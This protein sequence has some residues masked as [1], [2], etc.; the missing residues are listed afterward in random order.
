MALTSLANNPEKLK[1]FALVL[2]ET[3]FFKVLGE[4]VQ[5][6]SQAFSD[7][8]FLS[9]TLFATGSLFAGG[10]LRLFLSP[11]ARRELGALG[12]IY[13]K[14]AKTIVDQY[15][16]WLKDIAKTVRT[17]FTKSKEKFEELKESLKELK[18]ELQERTFE[19]SPVVYFVATLTT[20]PP[21][22]VESFKSV[23]DRTFERI[24]RDQSKKSLTL[25][26]LKFFTLDLAKF[27]WRFVRSPRQT[28]I[29]L[30]SKLPLIGSFIERKF[31]KQEETWKTLIKTI[32]PLFLGAYGEQLSKVVIKFI[33]DWLKA[34]RKSKEAQEI[35]KLGA[36]TKRA[37]KLVSASATSKGF[38]SFLS[39]VKQAQFSEKTRQLDKAGKN[40]RES[41][42]T[43]EKS[44]TSLFSTLSKFL[45]TI[46]LFLFIKLPVAFLKFPFSL[47]KFLLTFILWKPTKWVFKLL[48]NVKKFALRLAWSTAK[49]LV[50][51]LGSFLSRAFGFLGLKIRKL[52]SA[53]LKNAFLTL[54]RSSVRVVVTRV[55][56]LVGVLGFTV[57]IYD[58]GSN[59][60]YVFSELR[61]KKL[62]LIKLS[63]ALLLSAF[64]TIEK[65]VNLVLG[66]IGIVFQE[67][68]SVISSVIGPVHKFLAKVS[69]SSLLQ[70]IPFI[71]DIVKFLSRITG[72]LYNEVKYYKT[73]WEKFSKQRI[74]AAVKY[75]F[76]ARDSDELLAEADRLISKAQSTMSSFFTTSS[77]ESSKGEEHV[78]IIDHMPYPISIALGVD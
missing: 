56:P 55:L 66:G 12:K 27:V 21:T 45:Q 18:D 69:S 3:S 6:L 75:E 73:W 4:Q 74:K 76:M 20:L 9:A 68:Y 8:P 7:K 34:Y 60:F 72:D 67:M 59:I 5:K 78:F 2:E 26:M 58:L 49:T 31:A 44:Q 54:L 63:V 13:G 47:T 38:F 24:S 23:L 71:S 53:G 48:W 50:T 43:L 10:L 70:K 37:L 77:K 46:G 41:V 28:T 42:K 64:R 32:L 14:T 51:R 57:A 11:E 1:K 52:F 61:S 29:T 30:L 62:P 16:P 36:K 22:F 39:P 65:W 40:Y 25:R 33:E 17:L 35:E 15:L 19:V